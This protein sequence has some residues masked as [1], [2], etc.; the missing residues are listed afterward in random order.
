MDSNMLN[1]IVSNTQKI[2]IIIGNTSTFS[3]T[4]QNLSTVQRFYNLGL[5]IT[6]PDGLV[7]STSTFS[8]TSSITNADN[9]ITYSWVNMK[10]LAPMEVNFTF[11]I[12]VKCNT[13]FKNGTVI[14]FGYIFSGISVSCQADTMPRGSYDI[15]NV[16]ITNS[17]AMSFQTIMFNST[18][19]TPGKVLK[20][21]GSLLT[22]ND[23]TQ[24]STATCKFYNNSNSSSLV[25]ITILLDDGIRY[26]GNV[27]TLGTDASQFITPTINLVSINNKM[28]TQLYYSNVNLSVSSNTTLNFNFAIWNQYNSNQGNYIVHGTILNM[29]ISMVSANPQVTASSSST[30][31]FSAMDLIIATST[32]KSIVD[33]QNTVTYTYV[34]KVG[35]YYNI[36]NVLVHYLLPDGILYLS[37]SI[38]PTSV[39]NSSTMK[40]YYLTYNFAFMPQNSTQTVTISAKINSFYTY[41]FDTNNINLPVVASDPFTST[42]DITGT[43]VGSLTQVTDNSSVSSS[44]SVGTITKQF[45]KGYYKNGTSKTINSLAPGDFAEY[46]LTYNASTLQATQKQVYIDDFFP[47]SSNPITNLTYNYTGYN[48]VSQ[49]KLISPHGVDFFYGNI[50]GLTTA[51]ISFKVQIE[52]LGSSGQNANLMK[53]KGINTYGYAYSNRAQVNF[54]L[55]TP[56]IQLTKTVNGPNTTVIKSN[57]IYTYAVTIKNTNTLGTETDAFNFTLND[58]LSNW[59]T[60]KKNSL[61]VNGTGSYDEIK[62]EDNSIIVSIDKLAPG[63]SITL[64]YSVTISSVMAPG[65][66]ITTTATNTNPYSQEYDDYSDNY[67]YSNLNK[68]ASVNISS[69]N[70]IVSKSNIAST[71]KVGSLITYTITVTIPQGTIAYGLYVKD[72][73]P[74]GGQSYVG[75]A[76]KNGVSII[77]TVSSYT[78]TLPTEGTIDARV[79]SQTIAYNMTCRIISATKSIGALTSTQNNIAQCLYQQIQGGSYTTVSNTLAITVNHPNLVMTL[80]AT[81]K[82]TSTIYNQTASISTNSVMQFLLIFQNNSL[83]NLVNGTIQ[84]PIN[85]NFLFTS[86]NTTSFCNATYNSSTKNVVISIPQLGPSMSGYVTFTVIPQLMLVSGSSMTT[87]A[88]AVSYYNDIWPTKIYGGEQSNTITCSLVPGVSLLPNPAN[89]IDDST[90]YIVTP[91]GNTAVILNYFKN[92]GGGYDSYSITIQKVAISYTLYINGTKITDVP[93]NTLYQATL[94]QLT[95]LPPNSSKLIE[96]DAVI[97]SN[98][99]LGVRYDFFITVTS[100]TNPYPSKTVLNI[101]PS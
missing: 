67:Q 77:P 52:Q 53:L 98:Q 83:V 39:A 7:L 82:T 99:P 12:T 11:S 60:L 44:I 35:Q 38:N 18:V 28:Y 94:P 97:P 85:N 31:S 19:N 5:T 48:P 54:N 71:F 10:D 87:Q 73:L 27:T 74:N 63:Q 57:E 21:A 2:P 58:T 62:I 93:T 91:A 69:A 16:V 8:Q 59:F 64:T 95:N 90:S 23:Y 22:L 32:S 6:I 30:T 25:N 80:S 37:S 17:I 92:T 65:V 78:V 76:F 81:D 45:V 72:V 75:S 84:I 88:T 1:I 86:I 50:P 96:L 24:V 41:K 34:Y 68:S 29:Y 46:L 66:S 70:I 89:K 15:G 3:I 4:I 9:S 20:G 36:Q 61:I 101:D 47:L 13:K 49:P 79:S 56:N 55:G 42:T 51:T 40:G 14:P 33:I 100:Q 43:L 26:I